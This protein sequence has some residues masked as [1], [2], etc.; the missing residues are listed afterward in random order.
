MQLSELI[1][2]GQT[3]VLV[4]EMQRAIAG[5]LT[6]PAMSTLS[7]AVRESGIVGNLARLLDGARQAQAK[8]VHATL[9]FR[10]D[11]AGIRIV[12]PLMAVTMRDP[13]YLLLGSEQAQIMP[14]LGPAET[15]IVAAR[16]HGMSA[17]T[18]TDLDTILRSLDIRTLII[19]GVSLN[20]AIIG[21]SIEA[22]NLGYRIV[23][24]R[25]A[26]LG[27]PASFGD[28]MLKYAYALLGK[29]TTT[30]EIL[31]VWNASVPAGDVRGEV[32]APR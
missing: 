30:Q 4:S 10:R 11:R 9:Q 32:G 17:F 14:E 13:E 25:D 24:P 26:A 1:E 20:E 2:P 12:T 3:A 18:G 5:D 31:D 6:Q 22:V 8:V 19:G 15:D 16:T 29:V 23:I 27:M 7:D 28:D 21:A